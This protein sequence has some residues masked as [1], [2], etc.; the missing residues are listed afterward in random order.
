MLTM[1]EIEYTLT[2]LMKF[3]SQREPIEFK[4]AFDQLIT[5]KIEQ[6]LDDRKIEIAQ[7]IFNPSVDIDQKDTTDA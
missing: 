3:S 7:H 4:S 5:Q 6:E 2:D 1:A